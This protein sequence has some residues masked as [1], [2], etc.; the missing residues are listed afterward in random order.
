MFLRLLG[1]F[2][3]VPAV[4]LVLLI[5]I[6]RRIGPLPTVALII[7]TGFLG[8]A[9]ARH[10]GLGV[11]RT[12]Q[13]EMAAGQLPAGSLVDG[14]VLLLAAAV[15]MTP[16]VLTDALGFLCLVPA[17]RRVIKA[18]LWRRLERAVRRGSVRVTMDGGGFRPRSQDRSSPEVWDVTATPVEE[19]SEEDSGDPPPALPPG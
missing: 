3:V 12:I 11:L 7:F 15:L 5:E 17:T 1:L 14:V 19:D 8:A 13:K 6:G 4:E 9:L 10:Q 18:W 2:I 16:G